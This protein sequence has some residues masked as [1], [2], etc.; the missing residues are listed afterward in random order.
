MCVCV[1]VCVCEVVFPVHLIGIKA[2]RE[3]KVVSYVARGLR[4]RFIQMSCALVSQHKCCGGALRRRLQETI[5]QVLIAFFCSH[6]NTHTL[7][8]RTFTC[9]APCKS[10]S[11]ATA[12]THEEN[13]T[14]VCCV[15]VQSTCARGQNG[16]LLD[17]SRN[18]CVTASAGGGGGCGVAWGA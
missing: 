10:A 16:E 5:Y 12:A 13:I 14:N 1:N 7:E 11:T 2:L 6:T 18:V 8:R 17:S 4:W 9:S 3:L 15:R